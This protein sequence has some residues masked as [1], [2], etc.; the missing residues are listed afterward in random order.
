MR[1]L[2]KKGATPA[3][4][5][6]MKEADLMRIECE[7]RQGGFREVLDDIMDCPVR[8]ILTD[9]P[10]PKKYL[11]PGESKTR[12]TQSRRIRGCYSPRFNFV[13]LAG[14]TGSSGH[15]CSRRSHSASRRRN[16][17]ISA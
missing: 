7:V 12:T 2:A 9:P 3:A 6:E 4:S 5:H 17:A 16:A 1:T 10:Y 13:R 14:P 8:P 11:P 15:Q